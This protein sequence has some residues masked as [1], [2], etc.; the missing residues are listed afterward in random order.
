VHGRQPNLAGFKVLGSKVY[1]L[2]KKERD[3][4]KLQKLRSKSIIGYLLGVL[5]ANI[6]IVWIPQLTRAIYARDVEIDE[7]QRCPAGNTLTP[8]STS[9][10]ELTTDSNEVDLSDNEIDQAISSEY[11]QSAID[12][13]AQQLDQPQGLPTPVNELDDPQAGTPIEL[14]VE[15]PIELPIEPPRLPSPATTV[16]TQIQR[17]SRPT[18]INALQNLRTSSGRT[19]TQSAKAQQATRGAQA[20]ERSSI[21]RDCRGTGHSYAIKRL[22]LDSG[23]R[24]AF[25]AATAHSIRLHQSQ[26][27]PPPNNWGQMLKHPEAQGFQAAAQAEIDQLRENDTWTE[28]QA[29][30]DHQVLPLRWV[31]TY[32]TDPE[33]YLVRYKARLCV[34]GDLQWPTYD[35]IYAATGAYRSL[36]ILLAIVAV[37]DLICEKGDV[38]NA[39]IKA[40]LD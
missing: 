25:A 9:L 7:L 12:A 16:G 17:Q 6:F 2:N 36:R 40:Y 28:V 24:Q 10:L 20:I 30:Q 35:D 21:K 26:L 4:P 15:L 33:G 38:K 18:A 19:I 27:S 34:R 23:I 31:F 22:K 39:F 5:S 14:P 1:V 8:D 29:P 32:K 13:E 3:R 37:F 11:S